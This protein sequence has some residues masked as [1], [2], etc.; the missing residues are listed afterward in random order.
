MQSAAN[1][2]HSTNRTL[3][4]SYTRRFCTCG[5]CAWLLDALD[6]SPCVLPLL[7]PVSLADPSES[8]ALTP[9][10]FTPDI[11]DP[12]RIACPSWLYLVPLAYA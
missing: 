7:D 2:I 8:L 4:F 10:G 1:R 6:S 9:T 12:V 3:Y 11:I 5:T